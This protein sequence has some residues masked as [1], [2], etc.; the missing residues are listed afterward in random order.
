MKG[1][2]RSS[3]E[4]SVDDW[5]TGEKETEDGNSSQEHVDTL[6]GESTFMDVDIASDESNLIHQSDHFI[7]EG[8][9]TNN[10]DIKNESSI[11][12]KQYF[13]DILDQ[14]VEDGKL[15]VSAAINGAID[16]AIEVGGLIAASEKR[17][18][19]I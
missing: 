1:L 19:Q 11:H 14:Q 8:D 15:N 2:I 3:A 5:L 10:V 18:I 7:E 6:D 13:Y 17:E 12:D 9:G 4:D 16:D